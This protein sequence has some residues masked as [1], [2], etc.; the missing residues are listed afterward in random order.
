MGKFS[1]S[2]DEQIRQAIEKGEFDDLPGKGKP[3]DLTQNPY[4]DPTWGMA[5]KVLKSSGHTLPWIETRQS[6]E[7][8]FESAMDSLARTWNWRKIAL[9]EKQPYHL[10]EDEWQR[11]VTIFTEKVIE[12]NKRIFDYNLEV[13]SDQFKRRKIDVEFE[14]E[15]I[16]T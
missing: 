12:L 5:Y 16:T 3:L 4:E 7:K 10:I 9:E 8:E 14:I 11:S 1:R 6:I 13:P 2:L 15:R